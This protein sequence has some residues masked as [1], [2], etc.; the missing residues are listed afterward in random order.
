MSSDTMG[1]M[2]INDSGD[3]ISLMHDH[4]DTN[5]TSVED[6]QH[7]LDAEAQGKPRYYYSLHH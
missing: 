7:E 1:L 4:D 5:G 3:D 6:H 2:S